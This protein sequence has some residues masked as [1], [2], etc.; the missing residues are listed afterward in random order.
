MPTTEAT[1][2]ISWFKN[3]NLMET[4]PNKFEFILFG[5]NVYPV[6]ESLSFSDVTLQ[7]ATEVKL[8]GLSI[9]P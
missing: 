5:R 3:I 9:R 8:L 6:T 4:N 7:C 1:R 2:N